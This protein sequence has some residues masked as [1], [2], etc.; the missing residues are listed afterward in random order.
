MRAEIA[1]GKKREEIRAVLVVDGGWNEN[2]LSEVF[3]TIIPMQNVILP[4]EKP[5]EP[6][7]PPASFPPSVLPSVSPLISPL[8]TTPASS[9]PASSFLPLLLKFLI[10]LVIIGG[11][12]F[13]TW[14]YHSSITGFWNFS[15]NKLKKIQLL[16]IK[17][18]SLFLSLKIR[19]IHFRS[20]FQA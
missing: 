20:S 7:M 16:K 15:V 12:G 13:G 10:I 4:K 11:L 17:I 5:V 6:A 1:K 14:H 3:R 2:D 8:K 19:L 9:G 18:L